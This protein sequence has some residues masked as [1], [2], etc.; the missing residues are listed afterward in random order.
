MI[1]AKSFVGKRLTQAREAR[2]MT[3]TSVA[4]ILSVSPATISSYEHGRQKPPIEV[5]ERL[6]SI[7]NVAGDYFSTDIPA[8]SHDRIFWRSM[9]YATKAAR[10]RAKR[11]YEWLQEIVVYLSENFDFPAL[12]L[13]NCDVPVDFLKIDTEQIEEAASTCR[14]YWGIAGGPVP[15]LVRLAESKGILVSKGKLD[16]EGL[17]AFSQWSV[18][19]RPIAFL[20]SDK[21]SAVRS[22]FDL[23]HE[24]GH[25]MLHR[26]VNDAVIASPKDHKLIEVQAHRFASAFLLPAKDFTRDLYAPSLDAFR[27]LKPRWKVSIG[28]MIKRCA[29]LG[30]INEAQERRLWINMNR[31]GWKMHEPL[32]DVIEPEQPSL[33]AQCFRMMIDEGFKTREQ[34]L[35]DLRISAHDVEE[36]CGLESGYLCP[37]SLHALPRPRFNTGVDTRENIVRFS[38]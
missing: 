5:V 27:L 35:A 9:N 24:I 1:G 14:E 17:D 37:T 4:D 13:P 29:D 6:A 23:A 2:L 3:A 22:R 25:L 15:N 18:I 31:R 11:R 20:G 28:A 21:A 34:I 33:L 8:F 36:L 30:L 7:L 19:D 32:D 12:D 16:A 10:S 26:N 38:A